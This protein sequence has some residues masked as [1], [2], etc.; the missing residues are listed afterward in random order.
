MSVD[1]NR[2][3]FV[4]SARTKVTWAQYTADVDF[5]SQAIQSKSEHERR[6]ENRGF[7]LQSLQA[8]GHCDVDFTES[9]SVI[10]VTPPTL[11]RLPKAGLPKGILVGARA[12]NTVDCIREEISALRANIQIKI[13]RH[14]GALKLVPD[15]ILFEADSEQELKKCCDILGIRYAANPP[16]WILVNWCGGL[17]ELET[18][19]DF[20]IPNNLDWPRYDFSLNDLMFVR[21]KTDELPRLTRY[22]NRTT[23]LPIHVLFRDDRGAEVNPRWGRYLFFNLVGLNVIVYDEKRFRICVPL[24]APLPALISRILCL[25]SGKPLIHLRREGLIPAVVCS[26]W[27]LFD[28]VPP[29]IAIPALSKVGQT[30]IKRDIIG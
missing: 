4:I 1:Q 22:R 15:S 10:Y 9:G 5:L 21:S 12:P 25:C 26:D 3:L 13:F 7:L 2:L 17:P 29:Q 27:I 8:M 16:A 14:P 23:S 24:H 30:P 18:N 6:I 20:R 11:C 19:L 28:Q